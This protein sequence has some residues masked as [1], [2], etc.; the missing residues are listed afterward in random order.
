MLRRLLSAAYIDGWLAQT[1]RLS[2]SLSERAASV[3]QRPRDPSIQAES[4]YRLATERSDIRLFERPKRIRRRLVCFRQCRPT[5]VTI[6]WQPTRPMQ[7]GAPSISNASQIVQVI[8]GSLREKLLLRAPGAKSWPCV[9]KQT[10][11]NTKRCNQD[12]LNDT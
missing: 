4:G 1:S 8:Y 7:L 12:H 11:L 2:L 9:T 3:A 5:P 6:S 10:H